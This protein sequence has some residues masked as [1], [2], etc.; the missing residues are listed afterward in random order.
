M[1]DDFRFQSTRKIEVNLELKKLN[2]WFSLVNMK[3]CL[4]KF[5]VFLKTLLGNPFPANRTW[6]FLTRTPDDRF[7]NT[8]KVKFRLLYHW[9]QLNTHSLTSTPAWKCSRCIFKLLLN[10]LFPQMGQEI[11]L[12]VCLIMWNCMFATSLWQTW[13]SVLLLCISR[14]SRRIY[15]D[16]DFFPHI[17]QS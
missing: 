6:H 9:I 11:F 15:F 4:T 1:Q 10:I 2:K 13:H 8:R 14:W 16:P 5:Y 7:P 17:S 12:R 3:S